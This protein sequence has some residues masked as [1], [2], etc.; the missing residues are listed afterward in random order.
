MS[1]RRRRPGSS[2]GSPCRQCFMSNVSEMSQFWTN[3]ISCAG[4][5]F[6]IARVIR[7]IAYQKPKQGQSHIF[8]LRNGH[9]ARKILSDNPLFPITFITPPSVLLATMIPRFLSCSVASTSLSAQRS[10]YAVSILCSYAHRI[11][12]TGIYRQYAV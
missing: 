11:P 6:G 4:C 9:K 2:R 10:A 1:C 7:E 8:R 5:G 3:S 12:H